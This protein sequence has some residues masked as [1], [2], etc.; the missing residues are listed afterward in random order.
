MTSSGL[1]ESQ[2]KAVIQA[3][4]RHVRLALLCLCALRDPGVQEAA[5]K[6][7]GDRYIIIIEAFLTEV[8]EV[9]VDQDASRMRAIEAA[10]K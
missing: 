10:A 2:L 1:E 6:V 8:C 4:A 7:S 9:F 5:S 3:A